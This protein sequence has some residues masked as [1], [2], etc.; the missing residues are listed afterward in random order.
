MPWV[1]CTLPILMLR[2]KGWGRCCTSVIAAMTGSAE[3]PWRCEIGVSIGGHHA[4]S[5]NPAN[6]GAAHD[7]VSLLG[8]ASVCTDRRAAR[9]GTFARDRGSDGLQGVAVQG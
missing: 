9:R 8:N 1:R 3:C 7:D 2:R 6:V 5:N 4:P